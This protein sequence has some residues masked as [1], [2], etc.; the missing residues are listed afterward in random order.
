MKYMSHL[1]LRDYCT[2]LKKTVNN[3]TGEV[4]EVA[5]SDTVRGKTR[6]IMQTKFETPILN[7][8]KYQ[9]LGENGERFLFAKHNWTNIDY[10]KPRKYATIQFQSKFRKE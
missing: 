2:S 6:W 1:I 9:K 4:S 8:N 5:S 3:E 7:F 10:L